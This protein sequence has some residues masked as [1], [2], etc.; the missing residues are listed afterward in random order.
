MKGTTPKQ[1]NHENP[2]ELVKQAQNGNSEAFGILY[3]QYLTPVY[4]YIYL[5]VRDPHEAEDLTQ[6]TFMKVFENISSISETRDTPLN[7]FFTVARNTLIDHTKKKK[8]VLIEDEVW[9]SF[10]DKSNVGEE[11]EFSEFNEK[12][13]SS[14]GLLGETDQEIL[15]LRLIKE[16]SNKEIAE[17]LGKSEAAVRKSYSRALQALRSELEKHGF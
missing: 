9:H 10:A 6:V 2:W 5:R 8:A 15:S 17:I 4:R 12:V 3:T 1:N 7:F 14:I 11:A 16:L 13:I